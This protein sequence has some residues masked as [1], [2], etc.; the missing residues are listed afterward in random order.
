M[1]FDAARIKL[2][3]EEKVELTSPHTHVRNASTHEKVLM[4]NTENC[5]A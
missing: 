2:A 3:E 5:Q 1:N 4:E